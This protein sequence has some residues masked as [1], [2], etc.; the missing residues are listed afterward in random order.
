VFSCV[1]RIALENLSR[2]NRRGFLTPEAQT[3]SRGT[4][5]RAAERRT[6]S[7]SRKYL[8]RL[9]VLQSLGPVQSTSPWPL[10]NWL[11]VAQLPLQAAS[12]P[13]E[14]DALP[15]QRPFWAGQLLNAEQPEK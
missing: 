13:P 4:R 11:S 15:H 12:E 8:S 5:P 1:R 3:A 6:R 7:A 9:S 10:P 14:Q 2:R